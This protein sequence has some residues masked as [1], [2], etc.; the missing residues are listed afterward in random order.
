MLKIKRYVYEFSNDQ[1]K[2]LTDGRSA[3]N[4]EMVNYRISQIDKYVRACECGLITEFE[5]IKTIVSIM[6]LEKIPGR[7]N[8]D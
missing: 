3:L 8:N 2:R 7:E 1:I 6:E 4:S 5:T